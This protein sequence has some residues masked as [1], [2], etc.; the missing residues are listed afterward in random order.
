MTEALKLLFVLRFYHV[1]QA[2]ISRDVSVTGILSH[3]EWLR[4][5]EGTPAFSVGASTSPRSSR[6]SSN[7][8]LDRVIVTVP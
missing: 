3:V 8:S 1:A 4:G 6:S 5:W 2:L 7:Q